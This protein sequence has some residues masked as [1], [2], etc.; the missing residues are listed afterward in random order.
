MKISNLIYT[1]LITNFMV[2][3]T[4]ESTKTFFGDKEQNRVIIVDVEKMKLSEP[5]H[6]VFT[7][8]QITYTAD[9][10][11][12]K[13]KVYAVNRGSNAIDVINTNTH[14]LTKTI[15]LQ[16]FPRSAEAMNEKLHLNETSGMDKPMASIIDIHNDEVIAT[17]GIN[18]KVDPK[19]NPNFG[20]SHATGHPFWLN[21]NHFVLLDRY[22]RKV[23]T[24]HIEKNNADKWVTTKLNEVNTTSSVHA[25]VTREGNYK[26]DDNVF[27]ATGEGAKNIHPSIIKFKL[28]PNEGLR[29]VAELQLHKEGVNVNE[30]G[31][32]HADFHP[33]KKL[34][35]VGSNEGTLFI[36]DYERMKIKKTISVGKGAGHTV[37]IPEK[38]MAIVINHKDVFVSIINT[39]THKKIKD[40]VVSDANHLVGKT[41]IQAHPEY[42][43]SRY[44]EFFFAF[45]TVEG[46]MYKIDLN[47]LKLIK[48]LFVGGQPSQGSFVSMN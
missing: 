12:G 31:L 26:G 41:M 47:R 16:H 13:P 23:I 7:G 6:E 48:K 11:F 21:S 27:Y 18:E 10:V 14:E 19:N 30:M 42:H 36:V 1:V 20:G 24:Y 44:A 45:L 34:I 39:K 37:M 32:H 9:K 3:C 8:H 28:I 29:Q 2:G 43:V 22:N 25:F 38:N 17:V 35:Y 15:A 40:I 4:D 5:T 46:Q 33:R